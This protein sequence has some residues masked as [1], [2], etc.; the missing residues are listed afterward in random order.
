MFGQYGAEAM[1]LASRADA[2]LW[3]DDLIQAQLAANEFGARRAWTQIMIEQ[4]ALVGQITA[5]EHERATAA[6]VGLE[7]VNTNFDVSS[8]LRAV[9]MSDATPWRWPLKQFVRVFTQPAGDLQN[10]LAIFIDFISRLYREP[11]L[12][13][14]RC[15]VVTALLD[16]LWR[17]VSLRRPLIELRRAGKQFFGLNHVGQSQFEECF[18]QW[19]R[20]V[21][22]MIV[23]P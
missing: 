19:Y 14:S 23:S 6:L 22:E 2:V 21:T 1:M 11:Y 17:H 5:A 9:E 10:L 16:G 3:T 20:T 7:Y 4:I 8:L 12:A 18:D 13:E 15:K